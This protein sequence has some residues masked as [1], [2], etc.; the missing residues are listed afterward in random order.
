MTSDESLSAITPTEGVRNRKRRG[1]S[2]EIS[3]F[4]PKKFRFF[5]V[6]EGER[7]DVRDFTDLVTSEEGIA[8]YGF[9]ADEECHSMAIEDALECWR[10]IVW[11]EGIDV[12][13]V[14]LNIP[15]LTGK[16]QILK[17]QFS[18]KV[19]STSSYEF[20]RIVHDTARL[21]TT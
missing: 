10:N 1:E 3:P 19:P 4:S 15:K 21:L 18:F 16:D 9:L 20:L 6:V 8:L 14:L 2:S 5:V 17:E 11:D 7:H 13:V 12:V